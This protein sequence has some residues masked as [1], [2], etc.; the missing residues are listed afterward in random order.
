MV[1]KGIEGKALATSV[2]NK[3]RG[4][5]KIAAVKAPGFGDHR[6]AMLEDIAILPPGQTL[7]EDTSI[8]LENAT[9]DMLGRV[10]P[11]GCGT[12]TPRS[13]EMRAFGRPDIEVRIQQIL[14]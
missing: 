3:L 6:K 4:G 13:Y 5:L 8:K 12:N 2:V 14:R 1:R 9:V 10:R 11:C 7:S